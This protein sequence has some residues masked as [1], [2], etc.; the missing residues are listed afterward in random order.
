MMGANLLFFDRYILVIPLS[1]TYSEVELKA[2]VSVRIICS[3]VNEADNIHKM[4]L[5]SFSN[6]LCLF[7]QDTTRRG[8]KVPCERYEAGS[9]T[10]GHRQKSKTAQ[11]VSVRL[12]HLCFRHLER[13]SDKW[14]EC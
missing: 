13:Y 6:V 9:I 2:D 3:S 14:T 12:P 11:C 4:Y 5:A 8:E 10:D 1:P 7:L